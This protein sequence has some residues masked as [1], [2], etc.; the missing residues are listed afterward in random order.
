VVRDPKL[1]RLR[2]RYVYGDYCSGELRSLRVRG[3]RAGGS[4]SLG[5]GRR[6]GVVSFGVDARERVHVIELETGRV[7]RLVAR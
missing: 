5:V 6:V 4:R 1:K 7:S 3:T 2:G